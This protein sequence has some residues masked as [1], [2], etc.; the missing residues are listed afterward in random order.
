MTADDHKKN[1]LY[2]SN[3]LFK[4]MPPVSPQRC[5]PWLYAESPST[6]LLRIIDDF[7]HG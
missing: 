4:K 5:I 7:F 1:C 6:A 3:Y 2:K